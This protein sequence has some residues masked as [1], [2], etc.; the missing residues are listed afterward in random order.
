MS[1]KKQIK[2][3]FMKHT[4]AIWVTGLFIMAGCGG[5]K[6]SGSQSDELI[7][8]DVMAKYP[9]KELILQDFMDVEYIPLETSDEFITQGL[10]LD[11]GKD[12][13]LVR[14]HLSDGIVFFFHR[15]GKALKKINRMGQGGE[16]YT[17]YRQIVLDEDRSELFVNDSPAKRIA[18]YDWDGNFKRMLKQDDRINFGRIHSF[19]SE[20]LICN[21]SWLENIQPFAILSKQDGSLMEEIRIP[22]EK[23]IQSYVIFTLTEEGYGGTYST[24]PDTY[25]PIIPHLDKWILTEQSSDTV[26]TYQPDRT[27]RPLIV[28]TPPV[29]SLEPEI[30]L[31]PSLFTDRYY[32][33]DAVKREFDASKYFSDYGGFPSTHLMYDKQE[34]AVFEYAVHNEDYTDKRAVDINKSVSVINQEIAA[35]LPL[36]PA[37]LIDDYGKGKLKGRLKEIAAGL[38]EDSNPVIMLLKCK[39][40]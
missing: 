17:A 40:Q 21:N 10:V 28:R 23:K 16:E 5:C 13:I 1:D 6:Q 39:K 9:K 26:Y 8:V 24:A 15:N 18:V 11:I 25:N 34:K 12:I 19:D 14:N 29:Q 27:M 3:N 30:F 36:Q 4:L 22:F 33:M 37:D 2:I 7:T 32:F 38:N 35:W 31:F 20:N